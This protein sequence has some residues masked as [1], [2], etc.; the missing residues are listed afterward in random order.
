MDAHTWRIEEYD[1]QTSVYM[2]LLEGGQA[3]MLIDTGVGMIDIA[4][5][6]GSLTGHSVHV[7]NTHGHFDHIGGNPLFEKAYLH[8]MDRDVFQLHS[9]REFLQLFPQYSPRKQR[10]NICWIRDGAEFALGGRT[11]RV[12]HTP[13][14]SLGSV[15]VLDVE[16]RWLFTGDT[17]C[18]AHVLLNLEYSTSVRAY[19][20]TILRLQKLRTE[21]TT[22]WPGH[23]AAPVEPAILD[24]FQQGA[25][26]I[27]DGT[28]GMPLKTPLGDG[29]L[30]EY[31]DI[32][33]FYAAVE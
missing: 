18:K 23:H 7:L 22:T 29:F 20:K 10:N 5:I 1:E 2:Y 12:I 19:A 8:E 16:R 25:E 3:A 13:G 26:Q 30:L 9:S 4:Q 31:Q 28:Q 27:L 11:L 21:F 15:C 6:A 33:I 14:H 17:C 24:Q 32:G